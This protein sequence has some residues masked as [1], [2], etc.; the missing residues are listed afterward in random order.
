[1]DSQVIAGESEPRR[2]P[3]GMPDLLEW[4]HEIINRYGTGNTGWVAK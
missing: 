4:A 3:T 1:M 2:I